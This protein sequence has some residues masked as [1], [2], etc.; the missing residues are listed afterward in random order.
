MIAELVGP[1]RCQRCKARPCER[2]GTAVRIN[3]L[4]CRL[5]LAHRSWVAQEEARHRAVMLAEREL[6]REVYGDRLYEDIRERRVIRRSV[7][8]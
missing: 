2:S 4:V 6:L 1:V 8:G 3:C 7:T 5:E